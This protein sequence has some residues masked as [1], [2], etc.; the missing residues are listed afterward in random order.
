MKARA[1]LGLVVALLALA[2]P[3]SQAQPAAERPWPT[4][5][6]TRSLVLTY[7]EPRTGGSTQTLR[8][9]LGA[10]TAELRIEPS[11]TADASLTV[12]V[13]PRPYRDRSTFWRVRL[14]VGEPQIRI[15]PAIAPE[16]RRAIEREAREAHRRLRAWERRLSDAEERDLLWSDRLMLDVSSP[17]EHLVLLSRPAPELVVV[18]RGALA[19]EIRFVTVVEGRAEPLDIIGAI[20]IGTAFWIEAR[21]A[22]SQWPQ[23][24]A[25][26]RRTGTRTLTLTW[27]GGT[28]DVPLREVAALTLRSGPLYLTPLGTVAPAEGR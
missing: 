4:N 6:P 17:F 5:Q 8:A 18:G 7:Q 28:V 27:E 10:A 13:T 16:R 12:E 22:R 2:P 26:L 20:G 1:L 15:D 9:R 24:V 19:P 21:Y 23:I 14:L 3:A 11:V 25:E